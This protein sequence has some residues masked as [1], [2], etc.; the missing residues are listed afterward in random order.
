MR[1]LAKAEADRQKRLAV[2]QAEDDKN[3]AIKAER[4]RIAD[5]NQAE[6][7]AQ[8]QEAEERLAKEQNEEHQRRIHGEILE[9]LNKHFRDENIHAFP[10][11][12]LIDCLRAGEIRHVRINYST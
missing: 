2:Q 11:A 10:G 6:A 8:E 5:E 9:D 3:E 4:E 1:E 12:R 7:M